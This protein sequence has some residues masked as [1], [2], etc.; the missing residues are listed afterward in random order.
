MVTFIVEGWSDHD[1]L[2]RAYPQET[3]GTVV[4]NGTRFNRSIREKIEEAMKKGK[5]YILTDPDEA[6][7]QAAGVIS[8]YYGYDIPAIWADPKQARCFNIAKGY[9][10]GIE[11]CSVQY[12]KGLLDYYVQED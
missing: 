1:A 11:Y 7:K 10:Y 4:L 5:V 12:L 9:R 2:K 8:L 6:G 3:V